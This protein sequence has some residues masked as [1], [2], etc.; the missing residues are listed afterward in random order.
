M[1]VYG[2]LT[3]TLAYICTLFHGLPA[4]AAPFYDDSGGPDGAGRS[5]GSNISNRS[6][7][8][9]PPNFSIQWEPAT[10]VDAGRYN[11]R[12]G[13]LLSAD[14]LSQTL[15]K[16][17]DEA[18]QPR[19]M[20]SSRGN[21]ELSVSGFPA[22]DIVPI[23]FVAYGFRLALEGWENPDAYQYGRYYFLWNNVR[24]GFIE[25]RKLRQSTSSHSSYIG[26]NLSPE[27]SPSQ[28][29]NHTLLAFRNHSS[30]GKSTLDSCSIPEEN[31]LSPGFRDSFSERTFPS[32]RSYFLIILHLIIVVAEKDIDGKDSFG[33]MTLYSNG[34][35]VAFESAMPPPYEDRGNFKNNCWMVLLRHL[36]FLPLRMNPP[37]YLV[38]KS[39]MT[40]QLSQGEVD[41]GYCT[42]SPAGLPRSFTPNDAYNH[43]VS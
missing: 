3:V 6:L 29:S 41:L 39:V 20:R 38:T 25:I 43:T 18:I 5:L 1:P 16:P 31:E 2:R 9:P 27:L 21:L 17:W 15:L 8:Y 36:I 26:R 12:L 42:I 24:R 28:A 33:G 4:A 11:D 10:G 14:Y 7:Q 22:G 35:K 13:F 19:T 34:A 30:L 23:K 32:Y 37:R 40:Y